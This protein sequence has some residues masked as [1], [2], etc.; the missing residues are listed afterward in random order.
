[1]DRESLGARLLA[2][3]VEHADEA[4]LLFRPD[5]TVEY[6]NAASEFVLGWPS[7]HLVGRNLIELGHPDELARAAIVMSQ[8]PRQHSP[9]NPRTPGLA[10]FRQPDGTYRPVE[11][12]GSMLRD[13]DGGR[14]FSMLCRR[15]DDRLVFDD[16]LATFTAEPDLRQMLE[17]IPRLLRWRPDA[18][19]CTLAWRTGSTIESAGDEL[20]PTLIGCESG[21]SASPWDQA[22]SGQLA[23]GALLMPD[24]RPLPADLQILAVDL[25]LE[26]CWLRTVTD[27]RGEVRAVA[28]LWGPVDGHP[29]EVFDEPY[30]TA[31]R[32]ATLAIRWYD[33][34]TQL[35]FDARHDGLTGLANRR[36]FLDALD[37][38]RSSGAGSVLLVDLDGFKPV[39]DTFGHEAGDRVLVEV[40][41]RLR[42]GTRPGDVVARLGGDEFAVVCS[43][44]D[45]EEA[46]AVAARLMELLDPPI[47]VSLDSGVTQVVAVTASIGLAASDDGLSFELARRADEA[48]Y[49]AKAEGGSTAF[50]SPSPA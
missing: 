38:P 41:Q 27:L 47:D 30:S 3:L 12:C 40:A 11:I 34:Q 25:G 18:P 33:Q 23:G 50:S 42:A 14:I 20:P 16:V 6:A 37:E 24:L 26:R 4:V 28:S 29:L 10:R 21:G 7:E 9:A 46:A 32:L 44:C 22:W 19:R 5:G 49:R 31:I 13:A 35:H 17:P 43:D 45:A 8:R 15:V 2:D 1:V 39:N 36:V 48:L